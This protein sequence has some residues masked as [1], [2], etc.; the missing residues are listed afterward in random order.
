[1]VSSGRRQI[2][3]SALLA[4]TDLQAGGKWAWV[5]WPRPEARRRRQWT[6]PVRNRYNRTIHPGSG[7]TVYSAGSAR[8]AWARCTSPRPPP[9][10]RSPSRWSRRSSRS[11]RASPCGSTQRWPTPAGSRRSARRRCSTTATPSTAG[12]TW[13]PST[14]PG[15]RC[16]R[17]SPATARWRPGRCT[18]SRWAWPR[19]WRPSTS[20]AWCTATSSPPTSSSRC[21]APA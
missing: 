11:T 21:R 8:A 16:R 10:G 9:E 15:P 1:M 18:A 7:R 20:P 2:A 12:R 13:S 3:A 4:V 14:S 17:R 6:V 19:R 5:V